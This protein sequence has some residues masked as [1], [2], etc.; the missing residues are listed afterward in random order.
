MHPRPRLAVAAFA[1][2]MAGTVGDVDAQELK[3]G[4]IDFYGL[5]RV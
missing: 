2:L 5:S 3:I 1:L 4:I